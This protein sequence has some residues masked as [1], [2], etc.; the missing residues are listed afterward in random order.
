MTS[1]VGLARL[2]IDVG[3]DLTVFVP[4]QHPIDLLSI[5]GWVDRVKLVYLECSEVLAE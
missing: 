5:V 2:S 3:D 4:I 1:P